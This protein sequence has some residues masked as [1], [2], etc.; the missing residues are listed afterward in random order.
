[1]S[2]PTDFLLVAEANDF[3]EDYVLL[4]GF[5]IELSAL[6]IILLNFQHISSRKG[7]ERCNI[8]WADCYLCALWV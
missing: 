1:M 8:G 4:D 6:N 5:V 2:D 7:S 3:S